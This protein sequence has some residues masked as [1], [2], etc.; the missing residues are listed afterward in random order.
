MPD[1]SPSP[2][3]PIRKLLV[4]NRSEIA[5]RVF[6]TAHELG[7]RTVA[8]YSHEDRF[9][10]HRFK[11]DE[12]YRVG[13]PGEP[14]RAYLDIAGIVALA[15]EHE[16]DAIH[17]GYGFLSENPHFARACQEAGII[18]VGPRAEILEQ[19]GDKVAARRIAQQAGVPDPARQPRRRHRP[20]TRPRPWPTS[21]A[22][23]SSSRRRWAAAAGACASP[24]APTSSTTPSIRPAARPAR[25]FGISD[26]F[27][28]KFIAARPPH[29]GAAA[30]RPARQPGPSLRARLL[31]CSAGIRRSSRSPPPRT[32]TRPCASASSTPPSPSAGPCGST[33]PAP[34]SSS[35]TPT[36]AS[37]TSSRSIR[38]S[39]SSTPSPSR[40]PA[41]DIVKC[42][43]LVAQGLPLTDP[44]IG[45]GDQASV[46][47]ARLRHPVPGDHR[48][49]GQQ[50][51]A[52]LR[53]ARATI[54]RPAAWAFGSTPAP[55]SPA[56][57]SR[58]STI[59]CWSR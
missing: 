54:A 38:A 26:V 48:R 8:I 44:E 21:S 57:S 14:I 40:S 18:F 28:E 25:A 24:P 52:R 23:R 30:R 59:R 55:P 6:R 53:P 47:H 45:L 33:T 16:V 2:A 34:S 31:A 22:I 46:T 11:A 19:L 43:I 7:I 4:A 29:R 1:V 12:A 17:P 36:A 3:S 37:S 56:R 58:R 5:I 42:Q 9:A 20:T 32:S 15:R 10:L 39:R 41:Y 27:L 51:P 50:L 13:K 35:S 49:P